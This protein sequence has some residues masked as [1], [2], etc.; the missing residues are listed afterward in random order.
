VQKAQWK[1]P[2]RSFPRGLDCCD[3][4]C[5]LLICPTAQVPFQK[6]YNAMSGSRSDQKSPLPLLRAR[7]RCF[8]MMSLCH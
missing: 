5:L 1:S 8:P 3:D 4:E 7:A 6:N 2:Q